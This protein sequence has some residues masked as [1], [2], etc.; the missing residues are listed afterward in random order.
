MAQPIAGAPRTASRRI[1]RRWPIEPDP[2]GD[3]HAPATRYRFRDGR[4]AVGFIDS[5]TQ[6]FCSSCSRLRLTADGKFRV[7]LYDD[8]ET[9]LRGPLRAGASEDE[10]LQLM[11]EAVAGK[12][13]GGAVEIL[14][15]RK[16]IPLTRTMHQIGG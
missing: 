16:P 10:L 8:R 7:C 14:E 4:G 6:P 2:A 9:D 12:G 11:V 15:Q 1:G 3:P 13:R 5:V